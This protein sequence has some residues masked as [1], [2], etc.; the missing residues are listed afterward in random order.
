MKYQRME[1]SY[2]KWMEE[3]GNSNT[4]EPELKAFFHKAL[5]EK[6]NVNTFI[7]IGACV[8]LY[9]H[10]F[11]KLKGEHAKIYMFEPE[12]NRFEYLELKRK[13]WQHDYDAKIR[14][15]KIAI[16]N[17]RGEG[18]FYTPEDRKASGALDKYFVE[19]LKRQLDSFR[20]KVDTID[21]CFNNVPVDM[22]KMDVEGEEIKAIEGAS[23]LLRLQNP[24]VI[25]ESHM[26]QNDEVCSR[27][28]KF[29]YEIHELS[30]ERFTCWEK[31]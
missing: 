1:T 17:Y 10:L 18:I 5:I 14:V 15:F 22:I 11:A 20:V 8:G 7:D 24:I 30:D 19:R 9:S 21:N 26:K 12:P 6:S 27:M 3:F 2:L 29:G 28:K 25:I 13:M 23:N 4:Y 31:D 16:S